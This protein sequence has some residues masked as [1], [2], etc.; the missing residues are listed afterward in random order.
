MTLTRVDA[1]WKTVSAFTMRRKTA[2]VPIDQR[3][4]ESVPLVV[5]GNRYGTTTARRTVRRRP[6]GH[7]L[8]MLTPNTNLGADPRLCH[9]VKHDGE[10]MC[11]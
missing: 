4:S 9:R 11:R 2:P 8:E 3:K 6:L 1:T 7:G 5:A 10:R